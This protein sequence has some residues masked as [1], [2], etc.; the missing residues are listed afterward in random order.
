MVRRAELVGAL[1]CQYSPCVGKFI[2]SIF[3]S[4]FRQVCPVCAES[5]CL[6]RI[7]TYGEIG[8]MDTSNNL[9]TTYIENLVATLVTLEII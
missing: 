3:N 9:W 2:D 4:V 5:I 6:N 7:N 1:A 8:F